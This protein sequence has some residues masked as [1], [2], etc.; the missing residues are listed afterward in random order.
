MAKNKTKKELP[1]IALNE[2]EKEGVWDDL[3][4]KEEGIILEF[5]PDLRTGKI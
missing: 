3:F 4:I 1:I 5:N 2:G